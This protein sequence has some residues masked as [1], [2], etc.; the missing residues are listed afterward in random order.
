MFIIIPFT[1]FIFIFLIFYVRLKNLE[2]L[3]C[4]R[5][6]F[7]SASVVWGVLL[8]VITEIL[9]IFRLLTFGWLLGLW[10]LAIFILAF[11]YLWLTKKEKRIIHINKTSKLSPF[12]IFLLCCVALIVVTVGLIALISPPNNY[13]S[14]VY[15]MSRVAHWI[16]NYS[17]AHYPAD[18]QRQ[19]FSNP[20]AE[21]AIMHFQILSGGDRF[22]NL[23]Q[24]FSMVGSIIGVS[25]IA[26]LLGADLWGQVFSTVICATI[27]MGVLQGSSTQND[28]V[29]SFWLVCFVYYTLISMKKGI[30][31]ML[32]LGMSTSLG[33]AIL[34]KGT[35]YIYAFP[36]LIWFFIWGIKHLH[37]KLYKYIFIVVI[38]VISINLGHYGRNIGVYSFPLGP[39]KGNVYR[40]NWHICLM[41]IPSV[42]NIPVFISNII[43]NVD[44]HISTPSEGVNSFVE[45]SIYSLHSFLGI[46]TNDFRTTYQKFHI[47]K[48]TIHEDTASNFIHFIIIVITA[49]SFLLSRRLKKSAEL[50]SYFASLVSAFLLFCFL[51]KWQPWHSRLHLPLFV[52]WA[53]FIAITLTTILN[54]K[55]VNSIAI[56]LLL[57]SLPY[58]LYNEIRPLLTKR[59]IF[60]TSRIQLYFSNRPD[61]TNSYIAAT[62]FLKSQKCPD[63]GLLLR[64]NDFEY[65]FWVLL[66]RN[67]D[68]RFHIENINV[69]N[70]SKIKYNVYPFNNF[71]PCVIVSLDSRQDTEIITKE[72]A[73]A[74]EQYF[75]PV[76]IFIRRKN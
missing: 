26:K 14:M 58:I 54:K 18:I 11:I 29:V 63:I 66:Q 34:T 9:S 33:L 10:I 73:F 16:Q 35:A 41:K 19:L 71:S 55:I 15:H 40:G 32:L 36:F 61:L 4:W 30:S 43:R 53:P 49:G 25:L 51:F 75:E 7:L 48:F 44:L 42:F 57:S 64:G 65:P 69:K 62:D 38:V 17:V 37:W 72:D 23:I 21:F 46:N 74:K 52:L 5:T 39:I 70:R 45:K 31:L 47:P 6:S 67:S 22:A 68:Q 3:I 1:C 27:P 20:G 59:N 2:N 50:L 8:T 12:L 13:D 28:Y 24:W 60:N 76:S 56:I